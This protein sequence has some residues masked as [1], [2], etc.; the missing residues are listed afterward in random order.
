MSVLHDNLTVPR[1][2]EMAAPSI[3]RSGARDAK[4]SHGSSAQTHENQAAAAGM[5]A[6]PA[7]AEA[8]HGTM[9][10][11]GAIP[12]VE[13]IQR[14]FGPYEISDAKAVVGGPAQEANEAFKTPAYAAG[15]RAAFG[16]APDLRTAAHEATHILQ[17]RAGR[18]P[19]GFDGPSSP[20][21]RHADAVADRVASGQSAV[22]LLS[23]MQS[24]PMGASGEI[25][26]QAFGGFFGKV[27]ASLGHAASDVASGLK[28]LGSKLN[29]KK[30]IYNARLGMKG[31]KEEVM[32]DT[33]DISNQDIVFEQLAHAGA[34]GKL[35]N[36]KLGAWGYQEAGVMED[37]ESGFRAVLYV[38]TEEALEGQSES[39]K[40]ISAIHGGKPPAVLS[41]AGTDPADK[42]DVGDDVNRKGIGTYQFSSNT[43]RVEAA[44]KAAGGPVVSTGH[45]LGGALAQICAC[46]YP[47]SVSRVV[48]FQSPA[49]NQ[50]EV[51]KL[52]QHNKTVG[53]DKKV[54]STHYRAEG[55]VVHAA[56]EKL[57][58]GD[59]YTF[60]S[61]GVGW[62]GDHTKFPLARLNAARGGMIPGIDQGDDKLVRVNKSTADEE[63]GDWKNK[64]AEFGRTN[65]L[66]FLGQDD[67]ERYVEV[68]EQ[69][70][71]M[72]DSGKFSQAYVLG[73]IKSNPKLNDK[74]KIKMRDAVL[75]I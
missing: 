62:A 3:A 19:G 42:R 14:A 21:E 56:G 39:A 6:D 34:Y 58:K 35:D 46:R 11:Q 1:A 60:E 70:K 67:M 31:R 10:P 66:G 32:R 54:Q 18:S 5:V 64:I 71:K 33:Q 9:G 12:H 13:A 55:D 73:V 17:H 45:S 40:I 72:C 61:V 52:D 38:P 43:Q 20:Q 50:A 48:S 29:P 68:W 7:M 26:A 16:Q 59:V 57:T 15:G 23:S 8:M 37:P 41:F 22:D 65:M 44:L 36:R 74:Q 27:G 69:V 25:G 2:R 24:L 75:G 4:L 51:A 47:G 63:K 49:I 30:A 53:P 28:S